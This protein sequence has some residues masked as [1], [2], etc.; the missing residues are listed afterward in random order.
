MLLDK[1]IVIEGRK[2]RYGLL[3]SKVRMVEREP[4]LKGNEVGLRLRI[5]LPDALFERPT[6]QARMSIPEEA[7]P[8]VDISPEVTGNIEKIIKE[9]TGL[10]MAVSVVPFE[11]EKPDEPAG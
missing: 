2:G 5:D 10:T 8:V 9:A 6:L 1:Y 4:K 7:V 11:D 3:R